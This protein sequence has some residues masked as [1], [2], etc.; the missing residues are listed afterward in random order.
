MSAFHHV[1]REGSK[2]AAKILERKADDN[3]EG[4]WGGATV[5]ALLGF[6]IGGPVGAVV[7]GFFGAAGGT[8]IQHSVKH[9]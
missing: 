5:G 6:A 3:P 4:C 2:E 9:K 8:E 1:L 7:G